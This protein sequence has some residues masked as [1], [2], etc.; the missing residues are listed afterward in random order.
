MQHKNNKVLLPIVLSL[1]L[2]LSACATLPETD[3]NDPWVGWNRGAQSFNEG[4][5]FYAM[6]PIAQ[7]YDWLM[8]NFVR[9]AV[10]NFFSNLDD[11]SVFINAALQGKFEQSGLDT[12]RFLV[13]STL[14][15]GGLLDVG[16][17][18]ALPKHRE[19]FDQ[20]LGIWGVASGPY[21]VLPLFGPSSPRGVV[22]LI[23]DAGLNP[24]SYMGF[25]CPGSP[26]VATDIFVGL[27][28]LKAIDSRANKLAFEQVLSE[29]ALDR[30][31][32]F[33]NAYWA[34]RRYKISGILPPE[35]HILKLEEKSGK[36]LGPVSPY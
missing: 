3:P 31:E 1:G 30:Y 28:V 20:T 23:V 14:G 33:K 13:N 16:T 27:G 35:E 8:P 15:V 18:L 17:M 19:D 26:W 34:Q 22:G 2:M 29:A 32:F 7:G 21:L 9:Q 6:K 24:I 4:V 25:Y 12:A 5:D 10:S 11:I 36:G